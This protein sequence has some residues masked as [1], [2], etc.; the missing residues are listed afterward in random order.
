MG[1]Y[2]NRYEVDDILRKYNRKTDKLKNKISKYEEYISNLDIL[3]DYLYSE[4]FFP[5]TKKDIVRNL[6]NLDWYLLPIKNE[7]NLKDAMSGR[8]LHPPIYYF[9]EASINHDKKK[10]K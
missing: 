9:D 8:Y 2:I 6:D 7:K 10:K 3:W 4:K 1:R 5:Y